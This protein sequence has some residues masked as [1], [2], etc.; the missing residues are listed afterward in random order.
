MKRTIC[1]YKPSKRN[2]NIE[3]RKQILAFCLSFFICLFIISCA[4][5]P[6]EIIQD[7]TP[8]WVTDTEFVYPNRQWIRVVVHGENLETTESVA[9]SRVE[10]LFNLD[11]QSIF[12]TNQ[13]LVK[14]VKN[15]RSLTVAN[16]K[17]SEDFEQ[18]VEFN[19]N[20]FGLVGLEVES[21]T[22]PQNDRV[23]VIARMNRSDCSD[24]YLEMIVKNESI[25]SQLLEEAEQRP[26]SFEAIHLLNLAIKFGIVTDNFH[27]IRTVLAPSTAVRR[28]TYGNAGELRV[29]SHYAKRTIAIDVNVQGDINYRIQRAFEETLNSRGFRTSDFGGIPNSLIAFFTL[30]EVEADGAQFRYIRYVLSYSLR[31]S[32][33]EEIFSYSDSESEGH[34]SVIE[35]RNRAIQ[36][37]ENTIGTTG[38]MT[39]FEEYLEGL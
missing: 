23:Y 38:F 29:F 4:S 32:S 15:S 7:T 26:Q 2:K 8:S 27:A 14:R 6:E 25:I 17:N 30:D 31:T 34:L 39:R 24:R 22:N 35:A 21:W 20:E 10:R 12:N 11:L 3:I 16:L 9:I 33:G 36:A 1:L 28:L 13:Q 18:W 5:I 37:A 19:T